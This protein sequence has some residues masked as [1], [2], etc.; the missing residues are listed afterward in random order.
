MSLSFSSSSLRSPS[1]YVALV[2]Q[3]PQD[4]AA[5]LTKELFDVIVVG[6][7]VA[8]S[9]T[10]DELSRRG[11][12]VLLLE[13]FHEAH[14]RGSSHGDGRIIRYAYPEDIYLKMAD[15]SYKGWRD[16]ERRSGDTVLT[17][18]GG[19][20]IADEAHEVH[21]K[22]LEA[23][24]KSNGTAHALLTSAQTTAKFPAL[25]LPRSIR[26]VHQPDY[27]VLWANK[28]LAALWRCARAQGAQII[29]GCKV[30]RHRLSSP[31]LSC[32]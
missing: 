11:K 26:A 24:Y 6:G 25:R 17:I 3:S 31:S 21:L 2:A 14:S 12:K 13:Q 29:S 16:L 4:G 27:G 15:I 28:A 20:D 1:H 23:N 10:V 18:C 5:D 19:V 7:G 8:G 22:E 30:R 9:A 32:T